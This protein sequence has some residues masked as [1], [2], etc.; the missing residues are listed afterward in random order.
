MKSRINT[1]S[2]PYEIS[3]ENGDTVIRFFVKSPDAVY[4]NTC[5]LVFR[6][7]AKD[8]GT[9]LKLLSQTT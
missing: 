8:K 7:N 5:K 1:I 3:D 2:Y 4:P 9:L 6:M